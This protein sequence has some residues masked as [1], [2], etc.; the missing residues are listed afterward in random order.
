[1]SHCFFF[2]EIDNL[3]FFCPIYVYVSFFGCWGVPASPTSP[4]KNNKHGC[5]LVGP[6]LLFFYTG[7]YKAFDI[8]LFELSLK[9]NMHPCY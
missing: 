2:W 9:Q 8:F 4:K 6:Q 1:M 7:C 3:I 5:V